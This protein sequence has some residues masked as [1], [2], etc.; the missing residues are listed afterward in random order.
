MSSV[1]CVSSCL[2]FLIVESLKFLMWF[3]I[4]PES[5]G[6]QRF[7]HI[8]SVSFFASNKDFLVC[9]NDKF[10]SITFFAD[11][12]LFFL[13]GLTLNADKHLEF[14]GHSPQDGFDGVQI[15][16]PKSMIPCVYE[17]QSSL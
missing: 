13:T 6:S 2:I 5:K 4:D 1:L 12:F 9:I 11:A 7:F 14:T 10:I 16:A 15:V 3:F 17:K 8:K